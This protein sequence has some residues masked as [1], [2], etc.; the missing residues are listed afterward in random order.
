[1]SGLTSSVTAVPEPHALAMMAAG[2]LAV[3]GVA[4]RRARA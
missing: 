3:S 4:R 1:L 2:L